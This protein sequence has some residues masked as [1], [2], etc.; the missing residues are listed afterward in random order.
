VI[1]SD[2]DDEVVEQEREKERRELR[3][4]HVTTIIV[5]RVARCMRRERER[6]RESS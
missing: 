6:E 1:T 4:G 5:A 2:R 3:L